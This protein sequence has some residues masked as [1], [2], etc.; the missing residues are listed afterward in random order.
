MLAPRV[1]FQEGWRGALGHAA[2][3]VP[4]WGGTAG[5]SQAG[6]SSA[7][8]AQ[9]LPT[10]ASPPAQL[11]AFV[12]SLHFAPD[13]PRL[14]RMIN[15][16]RPP[17]PLGARKVFASRAATASGAPPSRARCQLLCPLLLLALLVPFAPHP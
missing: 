8:L 9:R 16:F 14:L 7:C 3:A 13:G 11:R 5:G 12:S 17:Q 6:G 15:N 10:P 4:G 1:R 2:G